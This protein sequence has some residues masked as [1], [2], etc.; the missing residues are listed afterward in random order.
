MPDFK[1]DILTC[2]CGNGHGGHPMTSLDISN[3]TQWIINCGGT[4]YCG[5]C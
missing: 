5:G 4:L 1:D 3:C 2:N